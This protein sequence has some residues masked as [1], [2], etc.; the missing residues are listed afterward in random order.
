M[1]RDAENLIPESK[2][3]HFIINSR[4]AAGGMGIVYKAFEPTCSRNVAIK[5]LRPEFAENESHVEAFQE[6]ARAVA[7]LSHPNVIPI[8]FIG[9]E[10]DLVYFA[11]SF[12]DGETFD[13]WIER[14]KRATPKE[15][16]WF[17]NQAS[18]ALEYALLR[19]VIHHDIKPANFLVEQNTTIL[20]TDFGLAERLT[21][22]ET[23]SLRYKYGTPY[24][25]SPERVVR[26][27]TDHRSD[28]Y[29]LGATLYHLMV[30]LPAY[31]GESPTEILMG[32]LQKEFPIEKA[33]E[34]LVPR[35]WISVIKKM[36]ARNPANR[37]STYL[38][39]RSAVQRI[40]RF[41]GA[42]IQTGPKI[43]SILGCIEAALPNEEKGTPQEIIGIQEHLKQL[44]KELKNVGARFLDLRGNTLVVSFNG[45]NE[46]IFGSLQFQVDST[47]DFSGYTYRIGI[48]SGEV[49]IDGFQIGGEGL[50]LTEKV[51]ALAPKGGVTVSGQVAKLISGSVP[52]LL[53][54]VAVP[55][56][57]LKET[58]G[59]FLVAP[60]TMLSPK[61]KTPS[62]QGPAQTPAPDEHSTPSYIWELIQV[63]VWVVAFVVLVIVILLTEF[64]PRVIDGWIHYFKER[65]SS[66]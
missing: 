53:V 43:F 37:F 62:L 52:F 55:N 14:G 16:A 28:I 59:V 35:E 51:K 10:D 46:A 6:E 22:N 58:S 41:E 60:N 66:L 42:E 57:D 49:E 61:R 40:G 31:E 18:A 24:Y 64:G 9:E 23:G 47:A 17:L 27:P 32:H 26:D 3:G 1:R 7:A 15:A 5:V 50:E 12:I 19:G 65:A 20:L 30:G 38:E 2:L 48:H 11:M 36:M 4:L 25:F 45:A 56:D 8:H 34:S 54:P 63:T 29:A 33:A 13:D 21:R 44:S 39:L